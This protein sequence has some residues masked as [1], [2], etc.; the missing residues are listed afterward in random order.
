MGLWK[1]DVIERVHLKFLTYVF[2]LKKS[3]PSHMIYGELRGIFLLTIDKPN[4]GLF[5]NISI[6]CWKVSYFYAYLT[7]IFTQLIICK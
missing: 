5:L 3:A 6:N 2:N 7:L 1:C 4:I